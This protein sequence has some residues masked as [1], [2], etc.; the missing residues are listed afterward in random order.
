MTER[1]NDRE[2]QADLPSILFTPKIAAI[3]RAKLKPQPGNPCWFPKGET[4]AQITSHPL[5]SQMH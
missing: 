2:E 5:P 1:E 3:A 4:G